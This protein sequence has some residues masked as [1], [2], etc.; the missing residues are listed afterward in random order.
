[1]RNIYSI[2]STNILLFIC[3]QNLYAQEIIVQTEYIP[4]VI[5]Q[6]T[7]QIVWISP[8]EENEETIK[9]S[10]DLIFGIV[11]KKEITDIS[12]SINQIPFGKINEYA[13]VDK[14]KHNYNRLIKQRI[15][16]QPGT[17]TISISARTSQG[18]MITEE[19]NIS[20]KISQEQLITSLRKDYALLFAIDDYTEWNDLGNPIN[21]AKAI[22]RE[23]EAYYGFEVELIENPT[24]E[25]ILMKLIEYTK[26][27]YDK[28]DQLF[29]FF[30]GHGQY[31]DVLNQG[32]LVGKDSKKRDITKS[33]YLSHT[34]FRE[35]IDNIPN[36]HIFVTIDA[37]FGG[38]FDP[39]IARSDSRGLDEIYDDIADVEFINRKLRF[40]TR[41]YLTSGGKEY[42]PDGI[43]GRHSPFTS[44]FLEALRTYGGKDHFLTLTELNSFMEKL[45]P[46][47]RFGSFGKNEAGSDFLFVSDNN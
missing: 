27:V 42:V 38:T 28:D 15:I 32:F 35:L 2:L 9:G 24:V 12:I 14:S 45:H 5:A 26:K 23:L 25:E 1:M 3:I 29:I 37:C 7:P 34:Y 39:L 11:C 20:L 31:D 8:I 18:K 16:L 47:P 36:N 43:A 6:D 21:D 44:R 33:S 17:N 19:R 22:K 40:K 4:V 41:K 46:E 30:A 10:Y 13:E